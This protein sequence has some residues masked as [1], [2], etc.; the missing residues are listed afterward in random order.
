MVA[1][2]VCYISKTIP[3]NAFPQWSS[4]KRI[5][6]GHSLMLLFP[7]IAMAGKNDLPFEGTV[8]QL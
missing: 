8:P 3:L 2:G 7:G 1:Q 6:L 5:L 4:I